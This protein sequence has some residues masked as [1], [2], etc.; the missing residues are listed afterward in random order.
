MNINR[1]MKSNE[2]GYQMTFSNM[3]HTSNRNALH[4]FNFH[5]ET[6]FRQWSFYFQYSI[7]FLL[8]FIYL[9]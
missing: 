1:I 7:P 2:S 9:E 5:S 3:L 4:I 8:S 6:L